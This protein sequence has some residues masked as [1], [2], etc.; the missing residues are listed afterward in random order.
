MALELPEARPA[1]SQDICPLMGGLMALETPDTPNVG[2]SPLFFCRTPSPCCSPPACGGVSPSEGLPLHAVP[3]LEAPGGS[4]GVKDAELLER[5]VVESSETSTP[6]AASI[7]RASVSCARSRLISACITSSAACC[8][9]PSSPVAPREGKLEGTSPEESAM[10]LPPSSS[11]TRARREESSWSSTAT[12]SAIASSLLRSSSSSASRRETSS[13][14]TTSW[15]SVSDISSGPGKTPA[16]GEPS[17][18]PA[19]SSS[20]PSK[21]PASGGT[22]VCCSRSSACAERRLRTSASS[23]FSSTILPRA[24]PRARH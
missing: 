4:K 2:A 16:E 10:P 3:I 8:R 15:M 5:G 12:A 6:L 23:V 7:A 1:L 17:P 22:G 20:L 24:S 9:S 11:A 13:A 19:A 18:L 14:S 21:A